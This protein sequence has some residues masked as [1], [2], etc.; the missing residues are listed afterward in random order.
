MRKVALLAQAEVDESVI[1]QVMALLSEWQVERYGEWRDIQGALSEY[2]LALFLVPH[3]IENNQLLLDEFESQLC[4][5]GEID[6]VAIV[7]AEQLKSL[8]I[9]E[10]LSRYAV[11]YISWPITVAKE[12]LV[13]VFGHLYGMAELRKRDYQNDHLAC[14]KIIGNSSSMNKIYKL[15]PKFAAT[16]AP[17]LIS[18]ESGTGKELIA[19]TL[20]QQSARC[21]EPFVVINCGA[22]P[23][24]L[25]ESELFGHVKG[26]FT[27]ADKNKVGKIELAHK[28]TLFL[29]E[30]GDLPLSQQVKLLRF[31]Q[32]GAINPV[33]LAEARHVDVRII[34][35]SHIKLEEAVGKG[36]FRAD[37]FYRL[38]VLQIHA[39]PL[40]ERVGDIEILARYFL[41]Q[42]RNEG[43]GVVRGFA[44]EAIDALK[45]HT[46]PGNIRELMNRV[47]KATVLCETN[48]IVASDL[49]L[50][51]N[52]PGKHAVVNNLAQARDLAEKV[53]VIDTLA[54]N[55]Q[56]VS[57]AARQLGVSRMTLY[58]LLD[59]H[60]IISTNSTPGIFS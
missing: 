9:K 3:Q 7:S 28:G 20:H 18:G 41:K 53:T 48:L 38:N 10:L 55:N 57:Q 16:D 49:D 52:K 54:A 29:D 31:L 8:A 43:L 37:L 46:W 24:N 14:D 39:P 47:R 35:A 40:I 50:L 22:I 13:A 26:A 11:D 58:R 2:L 44:K 5:A 59:K 34:A 32:E 42:Y 27:G 45:S 1:K 51:E 23:H 12:K 60:D 36:G 4:K 30:I 21:H 19:Q 25:V 56:N 6:W 15:I 17:V 33:G